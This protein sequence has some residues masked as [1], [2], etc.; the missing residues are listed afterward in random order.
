M[1][2]GDYKFVRKTARELDGE[3]VIFVLRGNQIIVTHQGRDI[4]VLMALPESCITDEDKA[5]F[6]EELKRLAASP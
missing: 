4:G 5:Q 3:D 2:K 6:L 1:A